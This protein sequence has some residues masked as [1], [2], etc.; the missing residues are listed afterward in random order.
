MITPGNED[1]LTLSV[2]NGV[3][4]AFGMSQNIDINFDA[5]D[6]SAGEVLS[7]EITLR[8]NPDCGTF[9]IPVTM[10]VYGTTDINQKDAIV[11]SLFPNPA[12]N[13]ITII[14][15]TPITKITVTNNI[16]NVVD[17]YEINATSAELFTNS[18]LSG[19]YIVNIIIENQV[20][21][22]Q[23]VIAK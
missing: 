22:K 17:I 20:I 10:T 6:L 16:G 11:T 3:L 21:S 18:Y 7:A 2:C 19:V 5:T 9:V 13:R 12:K 23:L 15:N 14:S 8:T 1:C 4:P